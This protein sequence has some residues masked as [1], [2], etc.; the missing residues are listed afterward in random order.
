MKGL[1]NI[2]PEVAVDLIELVNNIKGLEKSSKVE[3]SVQNKKGDW[4]K[5]SFNYVPLDDILNKIKENN[6]FALLQPIGTDENGI[7]GVKC[8]LIHKTGHVFETNTYP[9]NVSI[10]S[11]IQDEGAEITYRKRYSLGAF[12]GMA[13]EEDTDGNDPDA[14]NSEARKATP[15][16]IDI[17]L[18]YYEDENLDK[19]LE[20]NNISKIE[21]LPMSKASELIGKIYKKGNR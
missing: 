19:L 4:T 6:N 18:E 7:N 14:S 20:K 17:L 5:K 2:Q 11:K 3:Y 13:T 8:I 15:K 9:L 10:S 16:Q 21:D 1:E 12:L